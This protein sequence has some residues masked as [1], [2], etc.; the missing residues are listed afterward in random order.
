MEKMKKINKK[1]KIEEILDKYPETLGVFME[2]GFHCI[3]C[4]AASFETIEDGAKSHKIDVD[5]FVEEL[6]KAIENDK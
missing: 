2:H 3:G 6:N 4:A 5:K 1:M